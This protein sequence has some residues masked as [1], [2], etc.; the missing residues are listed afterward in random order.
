[1]QYNHDAYAENYYSYNDGSLSGSENTDYAE[2]KSRMNSPWRISV[3]AS[4]VLGNTAIVSLDY[5]RVAYNDMK[6]KYQDSYGV[7]GW[8]QLR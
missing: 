1:M 5:E 3:G 6:V 2:Y 4:G 8:Q 7:L